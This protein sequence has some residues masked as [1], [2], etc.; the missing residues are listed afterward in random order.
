MCIRDRFRTAPENPAIRALEFLRM[1]PDILKLRP[2]EAQRLI[3]LVHLEDR[4]ALYA[5]LK[6]SLRSLENELDALFRSSGLSGFRYI[7]YPETPEP[8][9]AGSSKMHLR[10][11]EER[12][13]EEDPNDDWFDF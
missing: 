10:I 3:L 11:H 7:L 1:Y 4:R 6:R 13:A 12:E 8:D 2:E 5:A 9:P